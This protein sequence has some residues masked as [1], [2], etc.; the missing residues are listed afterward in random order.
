MTPADFLSTM[1]FW[2]GF[3]MDDKEK[4]L[5]MK[6]TALQSGHNIVIPYRLWYIGFTKHSGGEG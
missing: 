4:Q 1:S 2:R 5:H 6:E 3:K